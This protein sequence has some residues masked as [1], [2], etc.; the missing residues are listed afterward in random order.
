MEPKGTWDAYLGQSV[1]TM[2]WVWHSVWILYAI[3]NVNTLFMEHIKNEIN[4]LEIR[5]IMSSPTH[6][7]IV[8]LV[9]E[10]E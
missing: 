6:L 8:S 1:L 7:I 4:N 2:E 5:P 3:P 10:G 9:M